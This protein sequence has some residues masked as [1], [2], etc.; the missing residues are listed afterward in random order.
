MPVDEANLETVRADIETKMQA[1]RNER[2][3]LQ[4][5]MTNITNIQEVD[6]DSVPPVKVI[7]EDRG[8]GG[9]YTPARR[10]S[11]YDKIVSDHAAL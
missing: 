3:K 10:D 2:A 11:V 4:A 9:P 6:D 8:A 7:P 5:I 1:N